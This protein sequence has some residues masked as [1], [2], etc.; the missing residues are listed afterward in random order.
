MLS[1][2]MTMDFLIVL[3]TL[4]IMVGCPT[5]FFWALARTKPA[6]RPLPGFP[7]GV[8]GWLL[9]F[10]ATIVLSLVVLVLDTLG[11]YQALSAKNAF[12]WMFLT[13]A[14]VTVILYTYTLY[15]ILAVRKAHV[16]KQVIAVLWVVG[17]ISTLL[18]AVTLDIGVDY[19]S[20]IRSSVYASIWT[21]YFIFS[22]RV[23][24]TYGTKSVDQFIEIARQMAKTQAKAEAANAAK[25]KAQAKETK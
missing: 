23:A 12:N 22:K 4:A 24:C 20:L 14:F 6:A 19:Q 9:V 3:T 11:M 15:L 5:Y 10:V 2:F 18:L 16:V 17:P 8:A 1:E 13:P 7:S 21:L 25:A